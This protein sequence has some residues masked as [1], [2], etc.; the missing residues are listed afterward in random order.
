MKN[1]LP[2][3]TLNYFSRLS[4]YLDK[5]HNENWMK[6]W[7][8]QADNYKNNPEAMALI[9]DNVD[10]FLHYVDELEEKHV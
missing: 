10:G 3:N 2:K 8:E 5:G 1:H 9:A 7:M 6:D 4:Q